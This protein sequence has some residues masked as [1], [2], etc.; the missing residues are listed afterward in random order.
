MARSWWATLTLVVLLSGCGAGSPPVPSGTPE[1]H[2][3]WPGCPSEAGPGNAELPRLNDGFT[4]VAVVVCGFGMVE[5]RAGGEDFVASERRSES[6]AALVAALRLPDEPRAK[7]PCPAI[8]LQTPWLALLDAQGRWVRPGVPMSA[9]GQP[10]PEVLAAVRDLPLAAAPG[11]RADEADSAEA[12]AAGCEQHWAEMVSVQA[13]FGGSAAPPSGYAPAPSA[14]MRLCVYDVPPA[15]R[16]TGKPRGTF[17]RGGPMA[18]R[19]WAAVRD[20][21]P[22]GV[23]ARPC[24]EHAGTF[25]LLFEGDQ[26]PIYVELDGCRRVL[27]GSALLQGT[28]GLTA[29]IG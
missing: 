9:C 6:V 11:R 29:A 15:E 7:G 4:P 1:V 25:A 14:R 23:A 12:T 19:R 16:G 8:G 27:V 5:Q 26:N 2:A 17:V 20:Q 28:P 13:G 24:R 22:Q 18:P 10:R 3:S 21:L